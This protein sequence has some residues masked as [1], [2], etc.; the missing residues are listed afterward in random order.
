[1]ILTCDDRDGA[2]YVFTFTTNPADPVKF[3][4]RNTENADT[5]SE[6]LRY[7]SEYAEAVEDAV[8]ANNDPNT[9]YHE[10]VARGDFGGLPENPRSK[11][12]P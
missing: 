6:V 12:T 11:E 2:G 1:M 8:A 4:I 10:Q 7:L 3:D 9:E 5:M